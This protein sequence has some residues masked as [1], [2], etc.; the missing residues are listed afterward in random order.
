MTTD[1]DQQ[2]T[3]QDDLESAYDA[4]SEETE[5]VETEIVEEVIEE[6]PPDPLSAP[7]MWEEGAK[8]A[9]DA[10]GTVEGGRDYQQSILDQYN[11]TESYTGELKRESADFRKRAEDW[12][13]IFSPFQNQM[14]LQGTNGPAF[15]RQLLG[16]YQQLN[17]NPAETI[18]GLAKQY[19]LDLANI[20]ENAP[21]RSPG[22][23]AQAQRIEQLERAQHNNMLQARQGV[24]NDINQQIQ[25]FANA[26]DASGNLT[27]PEFQTVQ[28]MMTQLIQGGAAND[29]DEAYQMACKLNPDIQAQAQAKKVADETA[30]KAQDAKKAKAA[31]KRASGTPTGSD[32]SSMTMKEQIEAEYDKQAA[33]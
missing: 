12:D 24:A 22:E 27:H 25:S 6:P 11:K 31:A 19:N 10:Y 7:H 8:A 28:P 3:L 9:F 17:S 21:Y 1:T 29:L 33:A 16:Y 4:Q 2:G 23:I 5:I 30:Q 32:D 26:T 14:N 15:M 13:A 18:Q 20:G